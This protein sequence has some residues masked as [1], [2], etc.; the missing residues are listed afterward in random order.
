MR[1]F[2]LF[3][4]TSAG[5]RDASSSSSSFFFSFFLSFPF[6]CLN[7]ILFC[8]KLTSVTYDKIARRTL[9]IILSLSPLYS[10]PLSVL[11]F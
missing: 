7:Q 1:G 8:L 5:V 11:V 4:K 3:L 2:V 10:S 6:L 9:L